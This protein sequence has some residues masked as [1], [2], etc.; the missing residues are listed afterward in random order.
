M[1][2]KGDSMIFAILLMSIAR[3]ITTRL[4]LAE[5]FDRDGKTE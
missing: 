2:L 3:I 5:A 1:S 4:A